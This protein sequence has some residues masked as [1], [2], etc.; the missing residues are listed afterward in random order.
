M[1]SMPFSQSVV[2]LVST[3]NS[4]SKDL[5]EHLASPMTLNVCKQAGSHHERCINT[6]TSPHEITRSHPT[7]YVH[8][9][10]DMKHYGMHAC[11]GDKNKRHM[12]SYMQKD[13]LISKTRW[14]TWDR[15]QIGKVLH[16]G[17]YKLSH[18]T[19]KISPRDLRLKELRKFRTE[20]ILAFPSSLFI[21]M[22]WPLHF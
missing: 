22:V 6:C 8:T 13:S 18:T 15:L 2:R 11:K 17:Y 20:V 5:G 12:K 4:V 10:H 1:K 3:N 9:R 21:G 19:K 14:T 16:M 7:R